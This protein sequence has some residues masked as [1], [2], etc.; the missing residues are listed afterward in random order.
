MIGNSLAVF[1]CRPVGTCTEVATRTDSSITGAG[2]AG[3]YLDDTTVRV[4]DFGAGTF[5]ATGSEGACIIGGG[6]CRTFI[7]RVRRL[8]CPPGRRPTDLRIR[9]VGALN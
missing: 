4:D 8:F 9:P 3:I 6:F 1:H 2:Y 5:V 7:D